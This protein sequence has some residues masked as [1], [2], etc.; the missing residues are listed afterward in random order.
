MSFDCVGPLLQR[1][2]FVYFCLYFTK[3]ETFMQENV[4]M[5]FNV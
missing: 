2:S 3:N 5:F 4:K 1:V